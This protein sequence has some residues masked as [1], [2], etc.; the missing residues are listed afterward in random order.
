ML[1]EDFPQTQF[2]AD[3]LT[4]NFSRSGLGKIWDG[5]R[6]NPTNLFKNSAHMKSYNTFV[7]SCSLGCYPIQRSPPSEN[8]KV[9]VKQL[10]SC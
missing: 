4:G 6:D 8:P 9:I 2:I 3:F 1:K 10:F 7:F 5:K